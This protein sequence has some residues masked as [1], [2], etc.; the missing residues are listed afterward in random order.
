MAS[1]YLG[2]HLYSPLT[3]LPYIPSSNG[4]LTVQ[5]PQKYLQPQ[6]IEKIKKERKIWGNSEGGGY[7]C[8]SDIIAGKERY[9]QQ[10]MAWQSRE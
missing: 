7:T 4:L 3:S 1:T 8:D 10:F 6:R 9:D 5:I 2:T